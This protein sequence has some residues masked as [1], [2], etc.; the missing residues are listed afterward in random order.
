MA[1][2]G[3]ALMGVY[4]RAL[5]GVYGRVQFQGGTRFHDSLNLH[6]IMIWISP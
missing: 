1:V 2:Y 4:G 3:R 5:M 6:F